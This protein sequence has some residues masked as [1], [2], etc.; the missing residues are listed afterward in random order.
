MYNIIFII[1]NKNNI[2]Y[3]NI[4]IFILNNKNI[5]IRLFIMYVIFNIYKY[6]NI[7]YIYKYIDIKFIIQN[8]LNIN[9]NIINI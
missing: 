4:Y 9:I 6:K 2:T 8:K 1:Q 5:F 7:K 3:K